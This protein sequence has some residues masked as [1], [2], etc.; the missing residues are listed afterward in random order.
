MVSRENTFYS[1]HCAKRTQFVDY[2][3]R[4]ADL[5]G[6]H[7]LR[8]RHYTCFEDPSASRSRIRP[9]KPGRSP[10][11]KY[12][13]KCVRH[14]EHTAICQEEPGNQANSVDGG[15]KPLQPRTWLKHPISKTIP[16]G[17]ANVCLWEPLMEI[18]AFGFVIFCLHCLQYNQRFS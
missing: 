2:W 15:P 18:R 6:S 8:E 3:T 16:L 12:H 13:P 11:V 17:L 5:V 4:C 14:L 7:P 10:G 9:V 1:A